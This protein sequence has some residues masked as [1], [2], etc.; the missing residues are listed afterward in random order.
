MA[1]PEICHYPDSGKFG[2]LDMT[3]GF[4]YMGRAKSSLDYWDDE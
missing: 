1:L 4:A 2:V 3:T